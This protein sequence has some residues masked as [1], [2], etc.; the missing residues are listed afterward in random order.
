FCWERAAQLEPDNRERQLRLAE[1]AAHIG[2][3]AIA[4]RAFLRAAQLASSGGEEA[5][6]L[7]LFERAHTLAPQERSVS[8]LYAEASLRAGDAMKAVALLDPLA[9]SENDP[10]FLNIYGNALMRAGHLDRPREIFEGL[11]KDK[12]EGIPQLFELAD[13]CLAAGQDAKSV[14]ILQML[15]RRLFGQKRQ[16]EFTAQLDALGNKHPQS[17]ALL[18]FWAGLYSELNRE[19]QYFEILLKLFDVYAATG[20]YQKASESIER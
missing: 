10:S 3:N 7:S 1:S 13:H 12:N 16:S 19:S 5:E 4:A 6:A 11:M 18:E 9:E 2:K 20:N 15:K 8:L 17:Q 14:D